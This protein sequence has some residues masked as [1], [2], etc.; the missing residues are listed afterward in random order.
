MLNAIKEK[1]D[2]PRAVELV[3]D[4][5]KIPTHPGV[6]G[7]ETKL[8]EYIK[9]YFNELGIHAETNHI[10]DGRENVTAKMGPAGGGK[11]LLLCGHLDTVPPYGM[12]SP[13]EA[14]VRDGKIY[15]RGAVDMKGPIACMMEAMRITSLLGVPLNGD[16]MFAGIIDEETRSLGAIDL[17]KRGPAADFAIVGEPT[18]LKPC[19]YHMGVEWLEFKFFGKSVHGG[20]QKDGINAINIATKFMNMADARI[21]SRLMEK[22]HPIIGCGTMNYGAI[23]GGTQPSTVPAECILQLD[24]RWLPGESYD[25]VLAE[26]QAIADILKKEYNTEITMSV[27]NDSFMKEGFIHP[28]LATGTEDQTVRKVLQKSLAE[29]GADSGLTYFPAWTDAGILYEYG[30]IPCAVIGPGDLKCA[31][32]DDEYI[33]IEDIAGGIALYALVI[34]N[35]QTG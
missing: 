27:M 15:G 23:R 7:Q 35:F 29:M 14:E 6:I 2:V 30:K 24:R 19:V 4:M 22:T 9:G 12:P 34:A 21:N 33:S 26:F 17:L 10:C 20:N 16:V 18:K 28:P 8:A 31:H 13:F 11:R 5:V 32:T 1:I 25:D 3:R